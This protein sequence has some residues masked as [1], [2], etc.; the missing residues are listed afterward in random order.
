[1]EK[2]KE[3]VDLAR[4]DMER[5]SENEIENTRQDLLS[6]MLRA[7]MNAKRLDEKSKSRSRSEK[8]CLTDEELCGNVSTVS[9]ECFPS[10]RLIRS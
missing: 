8:A 1:M 3:V 6:T 7:N 4:K 5:D 10:F 9:L 2:A